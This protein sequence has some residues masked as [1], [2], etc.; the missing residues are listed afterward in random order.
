MESIDESGAHDMERKDGEGSMQRRFRAGWIV[1]AVGLIVTLIGAFLVTRH[2]GS[3]Y[4]KEI[5]W[6]TFAVGM[7]TLFVALGF[8]TGAFEP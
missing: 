4:V 8:A 5:A 6:T 3:D 7:I 1:F 2:S